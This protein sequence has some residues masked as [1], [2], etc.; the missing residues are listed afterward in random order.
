MP[1]FVD[2][3]SST[4]ESRELLICLFFFYYYYLF[5]FKSH[6]WEHWFGSKGIQPGYVSNYQNSNY[7][8]VL[9]WYWDSF[10]GWHKPRKRGQGLTM[11]NS[12]SWVGDGWEEAPWGKG[13]SSKSSDFWA[14]SSFPQLCIGVRSI[15]SSPTSKSLLI[16]IPLIC[17]WVFIPT[18]FIFRS[19]MDV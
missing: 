2:L 17:T 7:S 8:G 6:L 19:Y 18:E 3:S 4:N 9:W 13:L 5:C 11:G 10:V 14:S 16:L 1:V 12:F 15:F